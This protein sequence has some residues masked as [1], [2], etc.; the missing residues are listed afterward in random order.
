MSPIF[1]YKREDT[2]TPTNWVL[3]DQTIA[4]QS[5]AWTWQW[6]A[7]TNWKLFRP[8]YTFWGGNGNFSIWNSDWYLCFISNSSHWNI[9]IWPSE[10][11]FEELMSH[12]KVKIVCD[13]WNIW[14]RPSYYTNSIRFWLVEVSS[15][16]WT[17]NEFVTTTWLNIEY[18]T[19]YSSE[20]IITPST[21]FCEITLTKLADW[22]KQTATYTASSRRHETNSS[23]ILNWGW[24]PI[25][26]A[27][28]DNTW[29]QA[30][31]ADFHIYYSS[32]TPQTWEFDYDLRN[33]S[34]AWFQEAW[35]SNIVDY[36]GYGF[37]SGGMYIS[38]SG[39]DR[40]FQLYIATPD[41]T[42]ASKITLTYN[43]YYIDWARGNCKR[44][45][46]VDNNT[47]A[48]SNNN[49]IWY[50]YSWSSYASSYGSY[51]IYVTS[52]GSGGRLDW[53]SGRGRSLSTWELNNVLTIDLTTWAT[54]MVVTWSTNTTD[55][56]TLSAA[57]IAMVRWLTYFYFQKE[58]W[59]QYR[60][61]RLRDIHI[62]VEF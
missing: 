51:G 8:N 29:G 57:Q 5:T 15:S 42:N 2:P 13:A 19:R 27:V 4:A 14:A 18:D 39:Y 6:I 3:W 32:D 20:I 38:W 37:D 56:W 43:A 10:A 55:T 44:S 25:C 31:F 54:S 53:G 35:G 12:D 26:S 7:S 16:A 41:L 11:N 59:Y 21:K 49:L 46:I 40:W 60:N 48:T 36:W 45:W 50:L 61:E 24:Y 47:N 52:G 22:T 33:W 58:E 62:K 9:H 1:I 34:L 30:R 17:W 28:T 23:Y